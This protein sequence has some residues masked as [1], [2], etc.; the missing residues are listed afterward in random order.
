MATAVSK[1]QGLVWLSN[2]TEAVVPLV[3]CLKTGVQ[4]VKK[5]SP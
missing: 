5:Y 2:I 4:F 3:C 1:H